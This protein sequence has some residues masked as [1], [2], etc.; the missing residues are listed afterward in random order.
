MEKVIRYRCDYCG[1]LL[2]SEELCLE[3]EDRH[4]RV[5]RAN[6]M[7]RENHT[8]QEI[9]D[10]CHIWHRVPEHL[11][12]VTHEN[13]FTISH[14]QCRNKPAYRIIGIHFNGKVSVRG[15]G[16]WSGWGKDISLEDNCLHNPRPKEELFVDPRTV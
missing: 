2:N 14:W 7:L 15:R 3:H 1:E 8:L 6:D 5:E 13:C 12:N 9:Q 10:E 16:Y 11:Q 4:K